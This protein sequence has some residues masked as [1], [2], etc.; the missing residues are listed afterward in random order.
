MMEW[1]RKLEEKE[2]R[3]LY[4]LESFQIIEMILKMYL[5][6]APEKTLSPKHNQTYSLEEVQHLS[7][8]K[9]IDNFKKS[10]D[11]TDLHALLEKC[12]KNRNV[13]A[14][15]AL[16]SLKPDFADLIGVETL[17]LR[18]LRQIHSQ[19]S[20]AMGKLAVEFLKTAKHNTG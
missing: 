17:T 20:K 1:P 16:I 19:T 7:L 9:L 8:K 18:T 12:V 11:N 14:H 5:C 15:H 10:N 4:S 13:V 2:G 3:V 6:R